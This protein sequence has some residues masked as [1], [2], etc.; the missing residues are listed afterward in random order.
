MRL[1]FL[2]TCFIGLQMR[3]RQK[4]FLDKIA[5]VRSEERGHEMDNR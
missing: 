5:G 3:I 2:L 4:D 1:P